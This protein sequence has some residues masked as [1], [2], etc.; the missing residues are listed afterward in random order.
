MNLLWVRGELSHRWAGLQ[1]EV[2]I[3]G[4]HMWCGGDPVETGSFLGPSCMTL[5]AWYDPEDGF[6]CGN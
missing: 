2:D 5:K 6:P 1:L 4:S 3:G